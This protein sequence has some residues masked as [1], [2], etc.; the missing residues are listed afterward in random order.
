MKRKRD[1]FGSDFPELEDCPKPIRKEFAEIREAI[2]SSE[3]SFTTVLE[4]KILKED[5]MELFQM[6]EVYYYDPDD[7]SLERLELSKQIKTKFEQALVKYKQY[8]KY[9]S[10][11]HADFS[12]QI[13]NMESYDE[14]QELKYD[15][16]KLNTDKGNKQVIYNEY[17]RLSQMSILNDE[18]PKL[19]N[20]LHWALALPY[21]NL[22]RTSYDKNLTKFLL[23]VREKMDEELYGMHKVKESILLFLNSRILNPN[24]QKC[25]LGLLGPRGCGKTS[26]V[27]LLA[28]IL[29]RCSDSGSTPPW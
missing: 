21:D 16:L 26:I 25:S 4:S 23:N 19:K 2:E 10:Q 3:P 22:K 12:S 18:Y 15:I 27:R 6:L 5:K 17:K 7:V 8:N 13:Q 9:S 29:G 11:D 1:N 24:M 14:N 28:T 20:W